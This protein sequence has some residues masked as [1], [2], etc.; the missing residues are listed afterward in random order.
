V[1]AP[2]IDKY[3]TKFYDLMHTALR[4]QH[5]IGWQNVLKHYLSNTWWGM[6]SF[7]M[8]DSTQF[9]DGHGHQ[10]IKMALTAF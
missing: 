6:A 7:G 10:L 5:L 2:T 1:Y 3:P 8:Q 9:H 4:D